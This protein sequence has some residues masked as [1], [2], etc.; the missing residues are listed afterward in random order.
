[1][2]QIKKREYDQHRVDSLYA[3]TDL[4]RH[5]IIH[6]NDLFLQPSVKFDNSQL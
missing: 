2:E 4:I 3:E 1:M 6:L 5:T